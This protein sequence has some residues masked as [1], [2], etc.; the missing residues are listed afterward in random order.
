MSKDF[1]LDFP[2]NTLSF[3]NVAIGILRECYKRG[4]QPNV[5]PLQNQCDLSAQKPDEGFNQW[6]G[7]CINKAQK[8]ASRNS[9][10]IK[11]W[12]IQTSLQS[13]SKS[14]SQLITFH[15]LDQLGANEIN[16]LRNQDRV[17]VTSQFTQ[18]VFKDYG[19]ESEYLPLG[20]DSH[21]FH[22]LEKRPKIEGVV[23]FGMGGK[24]EKR[25]GHDKVIRLWA[26]RY[27][28]NPAYRLNLAIHNPF[29]GRDPN[30]ALQNTK[31]FIAQALEGKSYHNIVFHTF[32]ATNAEYNQF[33]Q[34][35]EIFFALSGGEG[36][37][38][39]EYH[40]TAL[41]AWPIALRAH[42]YVDFLND[43]NAIMVNPTGKRPAADGI[44]F[45]PGT[46]FNDGNFFDFDETSFYKACDE[47]EQ[48]VKT[49]INVKG[50]ELQKLT[51][52]DTVDVLLKDLK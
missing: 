48:R 17:Y 28:N 42:S 25:K 47:A 20:F 37:G 23:Q 44:F 30:E 33:L 2:I 21:N 31:N 15:E 3:G 14:N 16:I 6:L 39:P 22:S 52:K 13:Y 1:N 26:K 4:L 45:A 11:L 18:R 49:G 50:L 36:K 35:S 9:T 29:L 38:L 41:G 43:E 46:P 7:H 8:E 51:Y 5:F 34:A 40:A 32:M 12:H 10:A 19:I 27:G 24:A